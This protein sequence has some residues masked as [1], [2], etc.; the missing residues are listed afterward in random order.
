MENFII[1]IEN[2]LCGDQSIGEK[3][4][5]SEGLDYQKVQTLYHCL[6]KLK[7]ELS[8]DKTIPVALMIL[9]LDFILIVNATIENNSD[10]REEIFIFLDKFMCKIRELA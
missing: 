2:L 7:I 10:Y 6:D 3:L 8:V 4:R 1:D 5:F 9:F